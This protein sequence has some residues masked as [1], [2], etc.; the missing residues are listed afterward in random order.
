MMAQELGVSDIHLQTWIV[1]HL[2]C[3][4]LLGNEPEDEDLC[5]FFPVC[6]IGI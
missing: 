2:D 4:G 1:F 6:C 5:L 3:F